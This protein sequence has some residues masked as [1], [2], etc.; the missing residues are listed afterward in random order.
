MTNVVIGGDKRMVRVAYLSV[1]TSI[2]VLLVVAAY[3]AQP[4]RRTLDDANCMLA[5]WNEDWG[6]ASSGDPKLVLAVW[7]DGYV[8]W[9]EQRIAGGGPYRTGRVDPKLVASFCS[10]LDRDGL[11]AQQCRMSYWGPDS[12]FTAIRAQFGKKK[13][14]MDSWHELAESH[15]KVVALSG[16]LTPLGGR[17]LFEALKTE[18]AEYLFFRFLWSEVR[19]RAAGLVPSDGSLVNGRLVKQRGAIVWEETPAESK[20]AK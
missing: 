6:L 15:G 16:G 8:A 1:V 12:F 5:I 14:Q 9:S 13:L 4:T 19:S 17:S 18:P 7:K 3:G 10:N 11:F 20:P 2:A